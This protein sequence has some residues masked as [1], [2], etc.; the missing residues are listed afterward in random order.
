MEYYNDM[1]TCQKLKHKLGTCNIQA[2]AL[3][4]NCIVVNQ[5]VVFS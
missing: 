3:V 2:H 4:T 1:N 5:N